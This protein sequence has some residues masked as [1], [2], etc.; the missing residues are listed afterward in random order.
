MV[1]QV[2]SGH[3]E[4]QKC[5]LD[6]TGYFWGWSRENTDRKA[7]TCFTTIPH[8]QQFCQPAEIKIQ[9]N[10]TGKCSKS[11]FYT[12]LDRQLI[13]IYTARNTVQSVNHI[14]KLRKSSGAGSGESFLSK[15]VLN[16]RREFVVCE[17]RVCSECRMSGNLSWTFLNRDCKGE[18][19]TSQ[20]VQRMQTVSP[21]AALGKDDSWKSSAH[22]GKR[23]TCHGQHF[24]NDYSIPHLT[25]AWGDLGK[26]QSSSPFITPAVYAVHATGYPRL[27][28]TMLQLRIRYQNATSRPCAHSTKLYVD[29]MRYQSSQAVAIITFKIHTITS[30][31]G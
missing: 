13:N 10:K 5:W 14:S 26:G 17:T 24:Q 6:I 4:R 16:R 25:A 15:T 2:S 21:T 3:L 18:P 30:L 9:N 8:F 19:W 11:G 1:A 27:Q 22:W 12:C 28:T 20:Q 7:I 31:R 23:V 29:T